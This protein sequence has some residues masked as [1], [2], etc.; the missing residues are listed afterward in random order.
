[1]FDSNQIKKVRKIIVKQ[2]KTKIVLAFIC[3]VIV[4]ICICME[5]A[6]S[7]FNMKLTGQG[8]VVAKGERGEAIETVATDMFY[9]F[10]FANG[11]Q[12]EYENS[13]FWGAFEVSNVRKDSSS[14]T[15]FYIPVEEL[16]KIYKT[17][18]GGTL[19]VGDNANSVIQYAPNAYYATENITEAPYTRIYY[20]DYI[21]VIDTTGL[22]P[23]RI[24]LYITSK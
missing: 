17:Y 3:L 2:K 5:Q 11:T 6:Y 12:I 24:N 16:Q 9:I 23:N 15:V 14:S 13:G 20:K 10:L 21:K 7:V 22:N 4:I 8:T 19:L 1:M 18:V